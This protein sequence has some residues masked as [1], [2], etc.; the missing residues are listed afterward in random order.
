MPATT[1]TEITP[2]SPEMTMAEVMAAYPGA[3]R[4]L[5]ANYHIGGCAKCAYYPEETLAALCARNDNLP[6]QEVLDHLA[7]SQAHD[8][9]LQISPQQLATELGSPAPPTLLDVRTRE[10]HEAVK[11]EPSAFMTQELMQQLFAATDKSAKIVLY[12][13][14]GATGLDLASYFRGH[15]LENTYCLAGGIDRWSREVDSSVQRYKLE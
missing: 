12:C 11:I 10:E 8:E 14:H 7:D 6:V 5:F 3:K 15:G 13:H 2:L 4:A 1:S 9:K